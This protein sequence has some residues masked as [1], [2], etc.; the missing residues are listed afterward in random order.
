M[1]IPGKA[2]FVG[3]LIAAI[4]FGIGALLEFSFLVTAVLSIGFGYWAYKTQQR[5]DRRVATARAQAYTAQVVMAT[6][7]QNLLYSDPLYSNSPRYSSTNNL[8]ALQNNRPAPSAPPRS[9]RN[10]SNLFSNASAQEPTVIQSA[11]AN[12]NQPGG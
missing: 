10:R 8:Q 11:A 7:I 5:E 6:P 12:K 1:R 4:T 9:P 2:L 3:G